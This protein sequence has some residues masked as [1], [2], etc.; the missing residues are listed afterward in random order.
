MATIKNII[1]DFGGV[2]IDIDYAAT[3]QAFIDLGVEDF[4]QYYTQ[5][6]SNSLF[7]LLETG[8]ISPE[9]F[10]NELRIMSGLA[11]T[12][13]QME[14]AWNA[15][16]GNYR[17][18][19]LAIIEALREKYAVYLFSN[20][21]AIHYLAFTQSYQYIF[22]SKTFNNLFDFAFYS[23]EIGHRKPDSSAFEFVLN[24]FG[25]KPEETLF[26]DDSI[27]NIEGAKSAGLHTIWLEQPTKKVEIEIPA[28]LELHK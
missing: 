15:M 4:D 22:G 19:G 11:L 10:Y 8:R 13:M 1:F 24:Q 18:D 12:N 9:N 2:F 27:K 3:Q 23:H 6:H 16:L 17:L 26:V 21:N 5:S 7:T 28:F 25:M 20:T 14:T